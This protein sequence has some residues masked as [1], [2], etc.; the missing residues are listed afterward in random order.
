MLLPCC[1]GFP[2][3]MKD[4]QDIVKDMIKITSSA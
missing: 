1:I 2:F 3:G 4:R